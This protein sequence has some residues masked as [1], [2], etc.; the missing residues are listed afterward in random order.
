MGAGDILTEEQEWSQM[1][2]IDNLLYAANFGCT[3]AFMEEGNYSLE[4]NGAHSECFLRIKP[5]FANGFS[6]LGI[7]NGRLFASQKDVTVHTLYS[8]AIYYVY[9]EYGDG[10]EN[11]ST[12]FNV[13]AYLEKQKESE[14]RMMLCIVDTYNG[15]INIDVN[16][17]YA[18]NLLAHTMDHT[19]PH[20]VVQYQDT[21]KIV[22]E[23]N[24]RGHAV[25]GCLYLKVVSTGL[26]S[27]AIVSIEEGVPLF[28]TAYSESLDAG[29]IAWKIDGNNVMIWN[30]GVPGISI[31][32]KVD[33]K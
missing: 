21:M 30:S 2:V 19:N 9:I 10:L 28:V 4:W 7:I 18:K 6:L 23:L 13:R 12:M 16:K 25:N 14:T 3:N 1:S 15:M 5:L 17:T 33:V 22:N 8:N 11:D 20:G 29:Q 24:V 27:P 31:N 32:L 26:E